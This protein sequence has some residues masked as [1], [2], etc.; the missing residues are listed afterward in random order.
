[1]FC[2]I[3]FAY[4]QIDQPLALVA[5]V[6]ALIQSFYTDCCLANGQKI[7]R[8]SAPRQPHDQMNDETTWLTHPSFADMRQRMQRFQDVEETNCDQA[9]L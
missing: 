3:I 2:C 5:A 7:P 1:M 4:I 8:I 6:D 9:K